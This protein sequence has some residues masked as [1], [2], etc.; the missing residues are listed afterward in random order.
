M[1]ARA[2]IIVCLFWLDFGKV[3]VLS[4]T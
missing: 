3:N 1:N 4:V 2:S